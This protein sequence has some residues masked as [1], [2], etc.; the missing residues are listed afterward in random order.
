M[1]YK[2]SLASI[3]FITSFYKVIPTNI[4]IIS[5]NK[6]IP[7]YI[8]IITEPFYRVTPANIKTLLYLIIKSSLLL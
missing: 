5:Y 2:V 3:N 6:V 7:T 8:T 4:T 1:F